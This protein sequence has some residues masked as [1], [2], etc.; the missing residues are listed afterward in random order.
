M[1]SMYA[2]K[3]YNMSPDAVKIIAGPDRIRTLDHS[4]ITINGK[5]YAF[6]YVSPE[7]RSQSSG[8][9]SQPLASPSPADL[10]IIT[11][12]Y[13]QLEQGIRDISAFVGKD[14]I[15]LSLLNGISSEEII[16]QAIGMEHMLYAFGLGMDAVREGNAI[17]YANAGRVIFGELRND[18]PG[19]RAA[20][21][22]GLPASEPRPFASAADSRTPDPLASGFSEKVRLVKDLFE[23][24]KIPHHIP[25]NMQKALWAKFMMNTGINQ[26]S[27][28]LKAPYGVF[29]QEG[30]ARR[31]MLA[32]SEEVLTLSR[33]LGI[34]LEEADKTEFLR[35]LD[36][37]NPA[38]KTSML[39]DIEA[40]RKSEV[41]L[42]AGT[43]VQLG[44]KYNISTPVNE[45]LYRI[46][47]AM[48][49]IH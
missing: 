45:T 25:A 24:A 20:A 3:L 21:D 5:P 6:S 15:V 2:E 28:V 43:V 17:R 26:V 1:G 13:P 39:Q 46:I 36:T 8:S 14:T 47:R 12:K 31:L 38:G 4:G 34:G 9:P 33:H 37:L 7:D 23:R 10:I 22:P 30:E 42:F 32:A 16:G 41:D 27:A 19:S 35:I 29:Q 11:V 48:E 49:Q 44:K 18:I 40:G